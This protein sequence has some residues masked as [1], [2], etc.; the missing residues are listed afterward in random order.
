[1]SNTSQFSLANRRQLVDYLASNYSGLRQKVK[2]DWQLKHDNLF[3][4]L[5]DQYAEET[6]A[7]KICDTLDNLNRQVR[8]LADKLNTLGFDYEAGLL[9][10]SNGRNSLRKTIE[11]DI[12]KQIGDLNDID[13]EF[14]K[15]QTEMQTVPT[16]QDADK[17]LKA[18]CTLVK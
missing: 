10:I 17:I 13:Y 16:L 5:S 11:Q 14:D 6:G 18:L 3:N 2:R 15:A 7:R 1:M 9:S 4:Q 8:V 12:E